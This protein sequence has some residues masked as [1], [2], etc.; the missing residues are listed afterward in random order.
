MTTESQK[1][2]DMTGSVANAAEGSGSGRDSLRDRGD[3][4]WQ[5]FEASPDGIK[6]LDCDGA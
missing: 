5:F 4:N 1:V 2:A 6:I 3:V